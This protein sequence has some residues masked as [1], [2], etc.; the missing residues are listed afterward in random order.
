ML[1][2]II[3]TVVLLLA[4]LFGL[5]PEGHAGRVPDAGEAI[6]TAPG[7]GRVTFPGVTFHGGE[8]AEVKVISDGASELRVTVRDADGAVVNS[9][10][11][12]ICVLAWKPVQTA[13]Y[14]ITVENLG[15]QDNQFVVI[16][17]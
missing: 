12:Y 9:D 3:G 2:R 16:T 17:N 14:S 1:K 15:G 5:S 8:V 10:T 11:G 6:K 7:L 13:S 4:G